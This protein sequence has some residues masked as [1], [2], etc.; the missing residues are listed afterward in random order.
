[1]NL[2]LIRG[3]EPNVTYA[4]AQR[5]VEKRAALFYDR[6]FVSEDSLCKDYLPDVPTEISFSCNFFTHIHLIEVLSEI[7]DSVRKQQEADRPFN[8]QVITDVIKE[9]SIKPSIVALQKAGYSISPVYSEEPAF[10]LDYPL[11][12]AAVFQAAITNIAEIVESET[13]WDQILEFRQDPKA[14]DLYRTF[15]LWATDAVNAESVSHAQDLIE[16]RIADREWA[17]RKHGF[18]TVVGSM[19][20]ILSWDGLAMAAGG[21]GLTAYLASPN[22]AAISAGAVIVGKAAVWMAQRYIEREDLKRSKNPE[23]AIIC[24]ARRRFQKQ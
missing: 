13:S 23:V 16:Q 8:D 3:P 24:E 15:R 10:N 6:I 21:A 4:C 2:P 18:K 20:S 5:G 19:S 7:L 17:L 9:I 22:W 12:S 14:L 11:G 1:M